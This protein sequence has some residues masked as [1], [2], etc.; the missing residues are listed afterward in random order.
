M[1]IAKPGLPAAA[2]E[3]LINL[4]QELSIGMAEG[5][6][7]YIFG[8]VSGVDV[9]DRG[10]IYVLDWRYRKVK[11]FNSDGKFRWEIF[12]PAG[13]GPQEADNLSGL[14]VTPSGI[15]FLNAGWKVIVYDSEGKYLNTFKTEF[16]LM[17]V[18]CPGFEGVVGIGPHKGQMLHVF[19]QNGRLLDSFGGLF[20]VPEEFAAMREAPMF[21]AP[22]KFS[23]SKDGRIF[24]LNPYRYEVSIFK[25]G[26]LA[27]VLKGKNELFKPVQ[28]LGRAFVATAAN[29]FPVANYI[30][31]ALRR[32][33]I[34]EHIA[35]VFSDNKQVGSLM[36]PGEM[37]AIDGQGRLYFVEETDYPKIIRCLA[38]EAGR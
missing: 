29:I 26:K 6:E 28:R 14:A 33:E 35:D 32:V 16:R 24:V 11:T 23:C 5:D 9:D 21:A 22:L 7:N 13:Q 25:Q 10:N 20:V 30:L 2:S 1:A 17:N 31:V 34:K 27:G 19:D 15:L 4:K 38:S 8:M 3:Q 36:L 18:G 37:V 12:I